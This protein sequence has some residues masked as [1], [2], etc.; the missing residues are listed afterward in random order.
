[1][2]FYKHILPVNQIP[3]DVGRFIDLVTI[4]DSSLVPYDRLKAGFRMTH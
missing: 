3:V 4:V 1:M 2:I